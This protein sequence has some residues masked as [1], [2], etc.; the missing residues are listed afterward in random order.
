MEKLQ[1]NSIA[2][3]NKRHDLNTSSILK[4]LKKIWRNDEF[5]FKNGTF[6][7]G[8]ETLPSK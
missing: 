8:F 7:G 4:I 5:R 6:E 2:V 3:S 1:A